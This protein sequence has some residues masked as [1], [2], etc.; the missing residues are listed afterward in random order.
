[1]NLEFIAKNG[2]DTYIKDNQFRK[3]NPLFKDSETYEI[4]QES[5]D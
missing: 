3:R 1:M 4:E 2:F 5:A